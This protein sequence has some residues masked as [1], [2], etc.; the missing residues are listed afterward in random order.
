[1]S[2]N[3][4]PIPLR[5]SSFVL[6]YVSV[7]PAQTFSE[8][9]CLTAG[10]HLQQLLFIKPRFITPL[11]YA[12]TSKRYL[13]C[14]LPGELVDEKVR[15]PN[16][17]SGKF[18]KALGE[19]GIFRG[20]NIIRSRGPGSSP[21]LR[22]SINRGITGKGSCRSFKAYGIKFRVRSSINFSGSPDQ[23]SQA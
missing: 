3:D 14:L 21:L 4:A 10:L 12:I 8:L 17:E 9:S 20:N 19:P 5:K 23:W 1:V 22:I 11:L 6:A 13:A 7:G 18:E 16:P 15:T 2:S